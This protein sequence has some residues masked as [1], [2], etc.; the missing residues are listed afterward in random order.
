MRRRHQKRLKLEPL[1]SRVMLSATDDVASAVSAETILD[2]AIH[3]NGLAIDVRLTAL[4]R[5]VIIHGPGHGNVT[6]DLSQLPA[7]TRSL[8]IS[9][10]DSVILIGEHSVDNLV[11]KNIDQVDAGRISIG[12][13]I[14]EGNGFQ[15][16]LYAF[17]VERI[18]LETAPALVVLQGADGRIGGRTLLEAGQFT[19]GGSIWSSLDS[20]GLSTT[21]S[22]QDLY[23]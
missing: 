14:S 23:V 1:E 11:L 16:G 10:F 9:S 19:E 3:S 18:K 12:T 21:S 17:D 2:T 20:L 6:I 13:S 15:T 4:D 8:Q 22:V 5:M 7:T